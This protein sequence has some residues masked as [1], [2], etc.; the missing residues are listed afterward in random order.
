M[1]SNFLAG[2]SEVV[3]AAKDND[4]GDPRWIGS[5]RNIRSS[6][7]T[8]TLNERQVEGQEWVDTGVVIITKTIVDSSFLGYPLP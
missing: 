6:S 7:R 4:L 1:A 2:P 8:A 5:E 3:E